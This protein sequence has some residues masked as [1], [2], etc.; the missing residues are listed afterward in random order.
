MNKSVLAYNTKLNKLNVSARSNL[1]NPNIRI[2]LSMNDTIKLYFLTSRIDSYTKQYKYLHSVK[3]KFFFLDDRLNIEGNF[4]HTHHTHIFL[5]Y[6][7]FMSM[8]TKN[9]LNVLLHEK[10]HIYQRMYPIM[11]NKILMGVFRLR[12]KSTIDSHIDYENIRQNPDLNNIIYVTYNET[13]NLEIFSENA[14]CLSDSFTRTYG[15]KCTNTDLMLKHEHPNESF[16]YLI[17]KQI[18]DGRVL[19]PD[20]SKYL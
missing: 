11:Y 14:K 9:K 16:A 17:S 20:I 10:I 4:P 6:K 19:D 18:I 3:W 7:H 12:V 2:K 8:S 1:M 5:P 15:K 13:Y